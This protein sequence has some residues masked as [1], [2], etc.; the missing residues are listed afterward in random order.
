MKDPRA[1][2]WANR[3]QARLTHCP[4]RGESPATRARQ[5]QRR[6]GRSQK[7]LRG[8]RLQVPSVFLSLL[9]LKELRSYSKAHPLQAHGLVILVTVQPWNL[10]HSPDLAQ[11]LPQEAPWPLSCS[12]PR[13]TK[14]AFCVSGQQ[15]TDTG[16]CRSAATVSS[17]AGRVRAHGSV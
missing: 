8:A 7:G 13:A 17:A 12:W 6:E 5:G 16:R 3:R 15:L 11:F 4:G 2:L 14:A 1:C 10:R 9:F